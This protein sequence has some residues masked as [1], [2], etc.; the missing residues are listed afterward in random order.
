MSLKAKKKKTSTVS[1][2][3]SPHP[4]RR[5]CVMNCY[6]VLS[7]WPWLNSDSGDVTA[8]C[9]VFICVFWIMHWHKAMPPVPNIILNLSDMG[10]LQMDQ[11]KSVIL[12]SAHST[13]SLDAVDRCPLL[14]QSAYLWEIPLAAFSH[15]ISAMKIIDSLKIREPMSGSDCPRQH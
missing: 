2:T 5:H 6:K 10:K 3:F 1:G 11:P 7:P 13:C 12:A 15:F 4:A 8:R 14:A 9:S